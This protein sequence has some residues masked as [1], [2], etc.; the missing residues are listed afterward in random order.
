MAHPMTFAENY[1]DFDHSEAEAEYQS[2]L[3]ADTGTEM[4]KA[5]MI[6]A[7][8]EILAKVDL[9]TLNRIVWLAGLRNIKKDELETTFI[10]FLTGAK[11]G[12]DNGK[13][14]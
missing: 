4:T 11:A 9:L 13:A 10:L 1:L 8:A 7:M 3:P 2:T 6:E 14:E 12:L 5:E